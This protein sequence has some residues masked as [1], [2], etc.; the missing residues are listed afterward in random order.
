MRGLEVEPVTTPS[1]ID[2]FM[3]KPHDYVPAS[4]WRPALAAM[5]S[6]SDHEEDHEWDLVEEFGDDLCRSF[7][8]GL[9]LTAQKHGTHPLSRHNSDTALNSTSQR[10]HDFLRP[11]CYA[12]V[13][14]FEMT[15][16]LTAE[17]VDEAREHNRMAARAKSLA[18]AFGGVHKSDAHKKA[19]SKPGEPVP[20]AYA[21][22][23]RERIRA[24]YLAWIFGGVHINNA[25]EDWDNL[26]EKDKEGL[27]AKLSEHRQ[28]SDK[29]VG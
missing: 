12:I 2:G 27:K 28:R 4:G 15:P 29:E 20:H 14:S 3:R 1:V 23:D 26:S 9:S 21:E 8:T 16:E 11:H 18:W 19:S 22:D 24:D 13:A 6:S 10:P 7:E 17:Q 25:H 5:G